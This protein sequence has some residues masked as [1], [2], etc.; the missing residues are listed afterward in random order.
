MMG[1]SV[2]SSSA[3]FIIITFCKLEGEFDT[4]RFEGGPKGGNGLVDIETFIGLVMAEELELPPRF[5][6][7][8]E[9]IED[10]LE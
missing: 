10:G 1:I 5:E 9:W 2:L 4:G 8:P 3:S 6:L 7:W